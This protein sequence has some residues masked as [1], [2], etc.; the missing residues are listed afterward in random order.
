MNLI[1]REAKEEDVAGILG[2]INYEISNSTVVYDYKERSLAFQLNWYRKKMDEGMPVIVADDG[3]GV[4]GFGTFG[5]F[6]PWEAYR[7]CVEHSIYVAEN[8]R[9]KG[10][11]KQLLSELITLAR[12]GGFH[13]MIAG[14]DATNEGSIRFHKQFGFQEVGL[15]REVG[16]KFEKWLDLIF[17]QLFLK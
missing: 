12:K 16:F 13:T 6:R 17:L 1:I 15:F 5:I 2:I 9:G 7:F 11:G 4:I 8:A 14:I 10:V 3:L